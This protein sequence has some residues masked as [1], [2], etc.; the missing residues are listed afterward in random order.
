MEPASMYF[1]K[2]SDCPGKNK[3]K[4]QWME[5]HLTGHIRLGCGPSE[6]LI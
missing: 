3:K 6:R 1:I 4:K 2:C 5:V